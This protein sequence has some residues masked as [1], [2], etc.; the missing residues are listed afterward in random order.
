[1]VNDQSRSYGNLYPSISFGTQL[2]KV[3]AQ[4]A[5]S[6]KTTRPTYRQL[7]ND[8]FYGNRYSLMRGNPLLDN[9]TIHNI[10]LQGMWKF[11]QFSLSYSDERGRIIH[12]TEQIDNTNV[13]LV[14]YKNIH[15]LKWIV[16]FVS[17]APVIGIWHPQLSLGMRKQWF[18][19]ETASGNIKLNKP[20]PLVQFN[21]TFAFS[22]TLKGELDFNYQGTGHYQNIY[23]DYH[24]TALGISLVKT[25]F[26]DRLS[27]KLA[28]EDLLDRSRDGNL[29]YNHHV[30]LWQGNYYD[31]R[32]FV[33]T[34]RYKFNTTR[35]KYKGTGAGNEEKNRL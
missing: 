15:S 30:Q 33:A 14:T 11:I 34:I 23:L 18:T 9:S 31:R 19:M 1:M 32:R 21:N 3:Q 12:W 25:F 22:K 17:L 2:G 27:I 16:P 7:S 4:I 6:A 24:Q 35:S 5:Y 28:G 10:S 20:M 13:V 8:V 29:V 26:N